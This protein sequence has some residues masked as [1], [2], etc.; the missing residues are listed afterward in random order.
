MAPKWWPRQ[1]E[2]HRRR[3]RRNTPCEACKTLLAS[4]KLVR[5]YNDAGKIPDFKTPVTIASKPFKKWTIPASELFNGC[6][7]HQRFLHPYVWRPAGEKVMSIDL[8][9]DRGRLQF[10][11]NAYH[12]HDDSIWGSSGAELLLL[13]GDGAGPG[14]ALGRQLDAQ[15]IDIELLTH[16]KKTCTEH[17]GNKCLEKMTILAHPLSFLIDT[18]QMCLVPAT[19]DMAYV[20]LSYVWGQV[21]MLKTTQENVADLQ[22]PDALQKLG[23]Q[24]PRTIRDAIGLVPLLG[25]RYLWV[26]SLCIPQDDAHVVQLHVAQM[27][28]IFEHASVTIVACDGNDAEFGLRGLRHSTQPR[29]LPG[30]LPLAPGVTLAARTKVHLSRTPW[31]RRGWTLQEQVFS[32]RSILFFEDTVQWVCRSS[33]YYEDVDSPHDIPP[34]ALTIDGGEMRAQLNPLDLSLNVPDLNVLCSLIGNYSERELTYD[35]DAM[36]AFSSTFGA[37]RKA[38]PRG[39]IHGLPISFL[40]ASLIWRSRSCRMVRRESSRQGAQCPP[41]WT[42]AG[43]RNNF[44]GLVWESA[45]YM[46]NP[47]Q[48]MSTA[49][50]QRFQ[51][52]PTLDWYTK[53]EPGDSE[54]EQRIPF[55]NEWHDYKARYMG[56]EHDLPEGWVYKSGEE[57][58]GALFI[59]SRF[60]EDPECQITS[61]T[62]RISILSSRRLGCLHR[63]IADLH[64]FYGVALLL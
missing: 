59:A 55:Q 36:S 11:T 14:F 46:K 3:K 20:T 4:A 6:D 52:I 16:W 19:P 29:S 28:A 31:S 43:W 10:Y 49:H 23:S 22:K 41:S 2:R 48:G 30:V 1:Q 34:N 21:R 27:A 62:S 15:F 47:P 18:Q 33:K 24:V 38:F 58:A 45:C 42:W 39:F 17:H 60:K 9:F 44:H 56:K 53:K 32:R 51:V 63:F 8:L 64:Q 5:A 50:W 57:D 25:E 35:E 7:T 61:T 37:M 54:E 13:N 40:D 26:D 12:E